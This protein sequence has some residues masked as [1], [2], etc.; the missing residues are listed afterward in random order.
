[1]C[2]SQ[3]EARKTCAYLSNQLRFRRHDFNQDCRI[4]PIKLLNLT[5]VQILSC[6]P[7]LRIRTLGSNSYRSV[8]R[9]LVK[10]RN[11]RDMATFKLVPMPQAVL[12]DGYRHLPVMSPKRPSAACTCLFISAIP[13][14]SIISAKETSTSIISTRLA[15]WLRYDLLV[16]LVGVTVHMLPMPSR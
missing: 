14:Y 1:M 15:F 13:L 2:K 4:G 7:G 6:T 10:V 8:F 9:S 11:K 5:G 16:L 3:R 12:Y